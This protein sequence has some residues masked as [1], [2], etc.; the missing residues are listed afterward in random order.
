MIDVLLV[1][2]IFIVITPLTPRGL[3]ASLPQAQ[4]AESA[5]AANSGM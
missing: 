1:L 2:I 5:P 3:T 4:H